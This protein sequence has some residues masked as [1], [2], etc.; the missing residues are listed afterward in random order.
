MT[1]IN[2][3]EPEVEFVWDFSDTMLIVERQ[4]AEIQQIAKLFITFF[5]REIDLET[6]KTRLAEE[7]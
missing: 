2:A 6:L 7:E 5:E 4:E 3:L 1:A